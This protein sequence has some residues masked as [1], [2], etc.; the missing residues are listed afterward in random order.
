MLASYFQAPDLVIQMLSSVFLKLY[1]QNV[2]KGMM[3]DDPETS[4]GT[5]HGSLYCYQGLT[6][7]TTFLLF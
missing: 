2:L 7:K 5:K 6:I 3:E 1:Y 4:A